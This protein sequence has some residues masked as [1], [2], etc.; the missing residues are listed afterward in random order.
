MTGQQAFC[1]RHRRVRGGM[2]RHVPWY[3]YDRDAAI[4]DRLP[5]GDLKGARHLIGPRNQFAIV[6][7]LLEQS[8]R[9][10]FLEISGADLG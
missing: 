1:F 7:A 6:T 2:E 8:L 3:H 5:D 9:M 4:A 10:S